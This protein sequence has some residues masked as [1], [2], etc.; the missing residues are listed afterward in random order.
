MFCCLNPRKQGMRQKRRDWGWYSLNRC[1]PK[2]IGFSRG[3]LGSH[4]KGYVSIACTTT[5]LDFTKLSCF[6]LISA[7]DL[8]TICSQFQCCFVNAF[9]PR[10]NIL[11]LFLKRTRCFQIIGTLLCHL[12][13]L[14]P[15]Q[16]SKVSKCGNFSTFGMV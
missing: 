3:E 2:L 12:H 16:K 10:H 1:W 9:P 5:T 13:Q 7:A 4:I 14:L 8:C 6:D 15:N 11:I